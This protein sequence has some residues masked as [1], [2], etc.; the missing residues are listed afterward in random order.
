MPIL[1]EPTWNTRGQ[2]VEQEP[3]ALLA[4]G[5]RPSIVTG[6]LLQLLRSH[7]FDVSNI[8]NTAL[9]VYYW[10]NDITTTRMTIEPSYKY[11]SKVVENNPSVFV[12]AG[13]M[14]I[15]E[16][17]LNNQA[18][19]HVD[20]NGLFKGIKHAVLLNGNHDIHC[21]GQTPLEAQL[22]SEE[23]F[24][25][26]LEFYPAIKQ[27]LNFSEFKPR[28]LTGINK[29]QNQAGGDGV[30]YSCTIRVDWIYTYSWTINAITPILKKV[31]YYN[32]LDPI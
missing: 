23:V 6:V 28:A 30:H 24:F 3:S 17:A 11:D 20:A 8:K 10:T 13:E 27:D 22:L 14:Q 26:L 5:M 32:Q 1:P 12:T 9:Q 18:I 25:R 4:T 19:H 16:F 29:V 2:P 21:I 31:G 15:R 7:F